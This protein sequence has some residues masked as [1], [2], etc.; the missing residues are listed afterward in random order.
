MLSAS[1]TVILAEEED[2]PNSSAHTTMSQS[3]DD[4]VLQGEVAGVMFNGDNM[5]EEGNVPEVPQPPTDS[6][7]REVLAC[8]PVHP[9]RSVLNLVI[10]PDGGVMGDADN[11][12]VTWISSSSEVDKDA[13]DSPKHV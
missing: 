6:N 11:V 13:L 5:Q 3:Q 1:I 4:S 8:A 7:Q 2:K 12:V 10:P 9:P